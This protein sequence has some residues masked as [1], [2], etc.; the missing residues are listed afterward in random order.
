MT[1]QWDEFLNSVP[2]GDEYVDVETHKQKRKENAFRW[3]KIEA[4]EILPQNKEEYLVCTDD[5]TFYLAY[6]NPLSKTWE[7]TSDYQELI[8]VTHYM[9]IQPPCE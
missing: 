9:K 4:N 1:S 6:Y 5:G 8:G 2:M 3:I 7:E